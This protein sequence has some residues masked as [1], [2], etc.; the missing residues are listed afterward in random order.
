MYRDSKRITGVPFGSMLELL[1]EPATRP[2]LF[3]LVVRGICYTIIRFIVLAKI[4]ACLLFCNISA[5]G[6]RSVH[7]LAPLRVVGKVFAQPYK[8]P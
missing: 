6:K 1:S 4:H 7:S 8:D 2:A 3:V 5:N